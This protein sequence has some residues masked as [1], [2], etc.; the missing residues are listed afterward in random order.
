MC[1]FYPLR[2]GLAGNAEGRGRVCLNFTSQD[3][4]L[5]LKPGE[6]TDYIFELKNAL[7]AALR[8]VSDTVLNRAPT[9]SE[10]CTHTHAYL[11]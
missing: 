4:G 6:I 7:R 2:C 1:V 3:V 8:D 5:Q 10:H 11:P 9:Y